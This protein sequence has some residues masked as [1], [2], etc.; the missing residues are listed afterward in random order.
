MCLACWCVGEAEAGGGSGAQDVG[1]EAVV[2]ED[3]VGLRTEVP[4]V[5]GGRYMA[6]VVWRRLQV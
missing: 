2:E 5:G 4:A 1:E 3:S 6:L